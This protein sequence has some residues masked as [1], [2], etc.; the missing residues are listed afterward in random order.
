M[1]NNETPIADM[2]DEACRQV[3]DARNHDQH[4]THIRVSGAAYDAIVSAK[5]RELARG[6]PP[7]LLGL[8][9]VVTDRVPDDSAE[10]Y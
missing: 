8:D 6:N 7:L 1:S 9:M 2:L 10:V 5:A 4:P 3:L